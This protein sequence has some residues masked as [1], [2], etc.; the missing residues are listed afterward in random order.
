MSSLALFNWPGS[1]AKDVA[2][3]APDDLR[4]APPRAFYERKTPSELKISQAIEETSHPPRTQ[5]VISRIKAM[6][7][8]RN[9]LLGVEAE[10]GKWRSLE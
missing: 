4:T 7:S 10:R 1:D 6:K 9:Y 3:A 2:E 8:E 5:P